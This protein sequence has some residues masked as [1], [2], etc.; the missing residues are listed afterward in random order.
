MKRIATGCLQGL[1]L[2]LGL[3]LAAAPANDHF[4]DRLPLRGL[5][6]STAG[7]NT[8]ATR[9]LGEPDHWP[10]TG[11][12]S[13]WW[14]W[15]APSDGPV[16]ITTSNSSFDTLLAVY[17]GPSVSNL[18]LV[19]NNDDAPGIWPRS[20]VQFAA[21]AGTAYQVA[22]DGFGRPDSASGSIQLNIAGTPPA[23][24]V[25]PPVASLTR[26]AD[27]AVLRI[28]DIE[29]AAEAHDDDGRIVQ[30]EFY[31][32]DTRLGQDT[33]HPYAFTWSNVPVGQYALHV[34]ATDDTGMATTSAV[35]Q[36]SVVVNPPPL[37]RLT[38][39]TNTQSFVVP[40][41]L[42][43]QADA[44]DDDG[45]Q[46][47]A[48]FVGD[49]VLGYD[50]N[51]PYSLVRSNVLAGVYALKAVAVDTLDA[52][53][54]SAVVHITVTGNYPP[55]VTLTNPPHGAA[56]AAPATIS[57]GAAVADLDGTVEKVEYYQGN[58]RLMEAT[59]PPFTAV[60]ANVSTGQY[61]L[62]A[63]A[64][65][66]GGVL[67]TS[68]P[69]SITVTQQVFTVTNLLIADNAV[70]RY[71]DNG[72]DQGTLWVGTNFDDSAWASGPAQLGYG[73]GDEATVVGYG[74]NAN[75]KYTTTYF[76][77]SF[78]LTNAAT[79]TN[80]AMEMIR[81]D[82]AVVYLNGAE[83]FRSDN[84]PLGQN[85]LT[86]TT[87]TPSEPIQP[88]LADWD[89]AFL[90]EGTNVVAVEI[91]QHA[92][93]SSDISMA[94]A[95]V[96]ISDTYV[97]NGPPTLTLISPTNGA[98]LT[99]P[100]DLV[101]RADAEDDFGIV[102]VEFYDG[103]AKL[104]Q[105]A[106]YPYQFTLTNALAGVYDIHA[107]AIDIFGVAVTSAVAQ[108]TVTG[109]YAPF[110]AIAT[111]ADGTT[112][113]APAGFIV[114]ADAVDLDG[115]VTRVEFYQGA[116]W[117]GE[118]NQAPYRVAWTE[119]GVGTY[120]L[121][122]VATDNSGQTRTSA[123]VT[124]S[125][126]LNTPPQVA[127]VTPAPNEAFIDTESIVLQA[128]ATDTD[129]GVGLVEFF[130][131]ATLLGQDMAS[132]FEFTWSGMATGTYWLSA[133]ATD[134]GGLQATSAPVRVVVVDASRAFGGLGFDGADDHVTFGLAA[135]LGLAQFTVETWFKWRGTG[136]TANT[137]GGGVNALPLVA[138][139]RGES[140][141][142]NLDMNYFLGLDPVTR[143]LVADLEQGAVPPPG[144]PGLNQPV[145]GVTPVI[146][147]VWHH[148]AVTYDGTQWHLF[149]DGALETNVYVGQ[150]PRSDSIQHASLA[151]ALNSEGAPSGYFG[152]VLDEVRIWNYPRTPGQ[153]ASNWT[154][155]IEAEAGLVG[156][157]SLDE[158]NGTVA[159]DSSGSGVHGTL[160]NEPFWT[161]GYSFASPPHVD[162]TSPLAGA[163][164][165][166]PVTIHIAASA[167]DD[168]GTVARV[169]FF[170]DD[171][172]L[173]EAPSAPYVLDWAATAPA[174][175]TLTAVATD[176][177]GLATTSAPVTILVENA[178]VQLTS[179]SQHARFVI[180]DPVPLAA[181]VSD[182]NGVIARV[183]FLDG[184]TVI[185]QSTSPPF[186]ASWVGASWGPH[187]LC[188]VAVNAGGIRSTSAVFDILVVSNLA[189]AVVIAS[190]VNDAWFYAP[191]DVTVTVLAED[192]DG[193]ITNVVFYANGNLFAEDNTRPYRPVW[194]Q[195]AL[196]TYDLQAVA[197]D[198]RGLAATS[199]VVRVAILSNTPPAIALTSPPDGRGY[200]APAVV[201]L[202]AAATD[203]DGVLRVDFFSGTN[204]LG[205]ATNAPFQFV[206][207][208]VPIGDYLLHAVATD[209]YG[210]AGTSAVVSI[211]VTNNDPP[212]VTLL[213]PTNNA[214]F[215]DLDTV[216]ILATATD[217][218]GI[219]QVDFYADNSP[220]SSDDTSPYEYPWSRPPGGGHSLVAVATDAVGLRSTSA[221]VSISVIGSVPF[222][223]TLITF[224]A[225]WKYLDNGTDQGTAWSA[226]GFDDSAWAAGPAE[227]GY[228]ESDQATTVSF[229]PDQNNV[230]ITTYFR[231]AFLVD[232]PAPFEFLNLRL[233]HDDGAVVYLNGTEIYRVNLPSGTITSQTRAPNTAE[234][235]LV[236]GSASVSLLAAGTNVVAVEMHQQSPTSSDLSFDFQL[237]AV[238]NNVLPTV[239]LTSPPHQAVFDAP[240]DVPL[241]ATAFDTGGALALVEFFVDGEKVGEDPTAPYE[242]LWTN[243]AVG[244]DFA[245]S[246]QATDNLG[247]V[248]LS[249]TVLITV[250]GNRRPTARITSPADGAAYVV[251]ATVPITVA[252]EDPDGAVTNVAFYANG[253]K[254]G[255]AA[256]APFRY[257]WSNAVIGDYVLRVLATDN[258]GLSV[259][260]APVAVTLAQTPPPQTLIPW[261]ALWRYLDNGSNPGATWVATNFN[262]ATWAQGYAQLGYGE[263]DQATTVG[264]GPDSYNKYPATFFRHSF[265]IAD[266]SLYKSLS[267]DLIMDDGAVVYINGQEAFRGHMPGGTITYRT[268]AS[269]NGENTQAATNLPATLLQTG[270]NVVAVE[271]H[272]DEGDSSDISFDL[273]LIGNTTNALPLVSITSPADQAVFTEP[274]TF[275]LT[276]SATD[277]DGSVTNVQ[278]YQD[279][280]LLGEDSTAPYSLYWPNLTA[281]RYNFTA[282]ATD[283]L[284]ASSTSAVVQVFVVV[285]TAPTVESF[286]PAEGPVDSLTQLTVN[287]A[288]PVTGVDAADLLVNGAPAVAVAGSSTTYTFF[289]PQPAEGVVEVSWAEHHGIVDREDPPKPFSGRAPGDTAR[290]QLTDTLP[291]A[292]V[293][294]APV[295]GATVPELT[296]I[297]LV[298]SEPVGGVQAADL[299]LNG[300]PASAVDGSLAGP[301]EFTV[302]SPSAGLV[303]IAWAANHGIHDFAAAQNA[304][305][306]DPWTY[307]LHAP[308]IESGILIHEIMYHPAS[309]EPREE[310]IELYNTN[311]ASVSLAGWTVTGGIDFTFPDVSISARGYL[312][313][314]ADLATFQAKYPAV[315]N[316]VGGWEGQLSN[317]D[318]NLRL[319]NALG[320]VVNEV[321]YAD[322]G[323]FAVRQRGAY[324][325]GYYGWAWYAPH[326][327]YATNT[328]NNQVESNKSLELVNPALPNN[329][330]QNW[331]PSTPANGTPG[332]PN[333]ATVADIAPLVCEVAHFPP[334]PLAT[335]AVTI[336]ARIVDENPAGPASLTLYNRNAGSTSPPNFT[337]IPMFD[338]GQN[339]DGLAG[340]GVYGAVLPAAAAGT[341]VEYYVSA[342]DSGGRTRTWPAAARQLDGSFAQTANAQYRVDNETVA[343]AMPM[344]RVILTAA[345]YQELQ[346]ML[347]SQPNS[348]AEMNCT[349]I[350]VNGTGADVRHRC[351]IRNRGAG[352]RSRSPHNYR[353]NV[354]KDNRWKDLSELNL[355]A[356]F[357][358]LQLL[359]STLALKGELP[360]AAARAVQLRINGTNPARSG[361]PVNG[362][363]TGSGFGSYLFLEPI[364]GEW[365]GLHFPDD[366]N[367]NVYRA[368]RYP[369]TANLDYQGASPATYLGLGYTKVSNQSAN[370]WSDLI[371]LTYALSPNTP[372]ANYVATVRQHVNVDQW[373]RYFAFC[374]FVN[375]NESAL[376][377]GVGDDYAMYRGI[378]DPRFLLVAHDFDTTLGMGDGDRLPNPTTSIWRMVDS[379]RSTDPASRA[380]FLT[381]FMRHNEFA[382]VYLKEYKRLL[383]TVFSPEI[384]NPT[385]DQ[386]LG[387]WVPDATQIAPIKTFLLNRRTGVLAQFQTN[388]SVS[389]PLGQSGSYYVANA[390]VITSITGYGNVLETRAVH[391]NGVPAV[392][393]AWNGNWTAGNV[394]LNPGVNAL[395]VQ[396]LGDEGAELRRQTLD[397]WYDDG[398][399]AAVPASIAE[400]LS[401]TA[402]GGPYQVSANVTVQA[403][404]TLTIEPGATLYFGQGTS[405]NIE[406]ALVA[407]GTDTRHIRLTRQPGTTATWGGIAFNDTLADNRL[408]YV[409]MEYASTGD[410]IDADNSRLLLDHVTWTGTTRTIVDMNMSSVIIRNCVFPTIADN[411]AVHGT[412]MRADGYVILEGNY[413]GGTTG[414]SDIIDFTGGQRPGPI[415][416]IL[417]NLFNGGS[418]D[419]LDLDATDAHIEG[420]T[421]LNIHQD[422]ARD[423]GSYAIA[424]DTGAAVTVVRNLFYN[425]DHAL[426][427]KNG[428]S[429]VF[430]NNTVVLIRTNPPSAVPASVICFG[431]PQ[432]PGVTG[433][434]G[435]TLDGNIFWD[436]DA[437]RHFLFFTNGAMFL[438][439]N[440]SILSGTNH[441]GTGNSRLDPRFVNPTGDFQLRSDSPARGTGP[442]GLDMG[443]YVPAGPTLTGEPL[444]PTPATTATLTVAGPGIT[445]YQYRVNDGVYQPETSVTNPIVLTG[446]TNGVYTVYVVGKT[447]AGVWQDLALP[448]ASRTWSVS[449]TASGLWINELLA[450][451]ETIAIQ[452]EHPDLVELVNR[453]SQ[454]VDLKD[455]S[456]TDDLQDP[457]QFTFP[458]GTVLGPGKYLVL[459]ADNENTP[460]GLH[461]GF[462][463]AQD[464]DALHLFSPQGQ[465]LDFVVFGLQVADLSVGRRENGEWGLT[466]PTF[467]EANVAVPVGAADVLR[468]NEWLAAGPSAG[469]PDFIELYNPNTAPA[470]LGGLYLTD[471][472]ETCQNL[473]AIAPLSYINAGGY[474]LFLADNNPDAGPSHLGFALAAE[475]GLIGLLAPDLAAIDVIAYGPQTNSI[476]MGRSPNGTTNVTFFAT[477]TPGSPNPAPSA[478]TGQHIVINEVLAKNIDIDLTH[479]F[480]P[481]L[482]DPTPEWIELYNPTPDD[483]ELEEYSLSDDASQPAKY[484]LRGITIPSQGH[485]VLMA[486]GNAPASDFNTGFGIKANGDTLYLFDKPRNGGA[487]LDSVTY[488][489]QAR[490]FSIGR[491]PDGGTNWALTVASP[492]SA[493]IV[494]TTFGDPMQLRINEWLAN[495]PP[496]GDDWIELFNPGLQPV[497]LSGLYLTDD[498]RT[499]ESR[500]KFQI[501]PLS[502]I[503]TDLYG[504]E[505]FIADDNA[506]PE[507]PDHTNFKLSADGESIGLFLNADNPV[508]HLAFGPQFE[509]LSQG[510][511]PDGTTNLALFPKGGTP[512]D[513]NYL[514]LTTVLIS[515]VLSHSNTNAL[516]DA[517]EV[518]NA[519]PAPVD[520]GGWYLSD[521]ERDLKK[522]RIPSP[523][524]VAP[525]GFAVFYEYQFN[526]NPDD[527]GSFSFDSAR[528]D[529]V[530]LSTADA[531]GN[532]T[533][534]RA[535]A[536]FDA[537]A[538]DVSFGVY[539]NRATNAL[540]VAMSRRSFGMDNPETPAE[541]RTGTG[542]PN[543]Y[544][545]VGPVVLS[546]IMYHPPDDD[547]VDNVRDEFIELYNPTDNPVPLFDPA[548]PNHTWR[549]RD[550][551]RFDFPTNLTLAARDYLLVVSFDPLQ[552]TNSLAAFRAAYHL[553]AN[554]QLA[555]PYTGKLDNGGERIDLCRPDS[556]EPPG[557]PDA[558]YVPYILVERV[559][560]DDAAPWPDGMVDGGGWSLQRLEPGDFGNDPFSWFAASPTPGPQAILDT[561]A[562]GMPDAWELAYGLVPGINDALDDFDGDGMTNLDEF[563]AGTL[564]NDP[565][566]QLAVTLSLAA[567]VRLAFVAM[568]DR[569]YVVEY[570][571][572]LT[573]GDWT[574]LSAVPAQP[575]QRTEV[576]FDP[577]S[578]HTRFYR[579]QLIQTP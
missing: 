516:E 475:H 471:A 302:V 330:G 534:Y 159:A 314:A 507:N 499:P 339:G 256:A 24:P 555:G 52:L 15:T 518:Q 558:G 503:G 355:N 259:T 35:A 176:N 363:S 496:G 569:A 243:V 313:V 322:E 200:F 1:A 135:P 199:A 136:T 90:I 536:E 431:E 493:N 198:N 155:K 542:A 197:F 46:G 456:L 127:L 362:S 151:T 16:S 271:V 208:P 73:D 7:H 181:A 424:T 468:I 366:P 454:P 3:N 203:T 104:G 459:Y 369:W 233:K 43:I 573:D 559:D 205:G 120:T 520:L 153:V 548:F 304:F 427:L 112:A 102:R 466:R 87:S 467:G 530:F 401:L 280:L 228:G 396:W 64:T 497:S 167:T 77:H 47:V 505:R 404:A 129:D 515:E 261:G 561:D 551:V 419:A 380:N 519:S 106:T 381:R 335:D 236:A 184:E 22:V 367:G 472:P 470:A 62:R 49:T 341:I 436:I 326:D 194:A 188:A 163:V 296:R 69:V 486:N 315:P 263:S 70:W 21:A 166:A 100:T 537:A 94:L 12:R 14:T 463:L 170:A 179:P 246:A 389:I 276:A 423:S 164:F 527:P 387:G 546:E 275:T 554:A 54:T 343:N 552:D 543:P 89:P 382:P 428:A 568:P 272:Q 553:P 301:Y 273:Q 212:A 50:T 328:A 433:G 178:I 53:G 67:A 9:E 8:N 500:T 394:A 295:P 107:V 300:I 183:E 540:F 434:A 334:V 29:L 517:L 544:P 143:V 478:G 522:F 132:P 484:A 529:Q 482:L 51:A 264:Y 145:R 225:G 425:N 576:V 218:D 347:S 461:L 303:D 481:T 451:N 220:L 415:I 297:R 455:F 370:D 504:F 320:D 464:G 445:D 279:T 248:T 249:P 255:D 316:V 357:I 385:A 560:Y 371:A 457:R 294:V 224:G 407:E 510:R 262:D 550:G 191:V 192:S 311:A 125:V 26:P 413:F 189:P 332:Q 76:R 545:R 524:V 409:D 231:H 232:D 492:Q 379:P 390:P 209:A 402:A 13:V 408:A 88:D 2:A 405:M 473:H 257:D 175:V 118:T 364:G 327:G 414:Y 99:V 420:N 331:A 329:H 376:C 71:L 508:D 512:G 216:T 494:V 92:P 440:H 288:E 308:V 79:Y 242:F 372:D 278:F 39:P 6:V 374:N 574:P 393:T 17:T 96:G 91:H 479:I 450:R 528:G 122:A 206:W 229:G 111:P 244:G 532:L 293:A 238:F 386:V 27:A 525:G 547:G 5:M 93:D 406:G 66:N 253:L 526:A 123:V 562:D 502:F 144:S 361:E 40:L 533:G 196:G 110:V 298:F 539:T 177:A 567:P 235:S 317:N 429:A 465:R 36:V 33:A 219:A 422:A 541:F 410:P 38:A 578:V 287:F 213:Q 133:V 240:A 207:S 480:G 252:A 305:V 157:W 299:L 284:G 55:T 152:G 501:A 417:N 483:V 68:P 346:N 186:A 435:A 565:Q 131:G 286:V 214:I 86:L 351:G 375:Y 18:T 444:S 377:N 227:L 307:A 491:V 83:V 488:G 211:T 161:L 168:D 570:R 579:V 193:S 61:V 489:V 292:I 241:A 353:I 333:S 575:T 254:L 400:D 239:L 201:A 511:L 74:G 476:A 318:D 42:V 268:W 162:I 447:S 354:P 116:T 63:V 564:P 397:V 566:S 452:G 490:D 45:L 103:P 285:S 338:D 128:A 460:P 171:A 495:P 282:V 340:D 146:P 538:R 267:L 356:N 469:T 437:N 65:D 274:A 453:G 321:H 234:N 202:E 95:L 149:L 19:A 141:A 113:V 78:V 226:P 31:Q 446:L 260:S 324:D 169:E 190:P 474:A 142:N 442:N 412:G 222:T 41:H 173:G 572:S 158:T 160:V 531:Q 319:R 336:T 140:D 124:V 20:G 150:P 56:Y 392:W 266:A 349:F 291:P 138:K 373:L 210:L 398:S 25:L 306:P 557:D 30:V 250:N 117:L 251:P 221:P 182:T 383:D 378:R 75:A 57:L 571:D 60:W 283:N 350:T 498:L 237:E 154:Q 563:H 97:S 399:L 277:R 395:L 345:E 156:R 439:V 172:R 28:G 549:L 34:V 506:G 245:L 109:N 359:C 114:E 325:R 441:P 384:F 391:V 485:I 174:F 37:V 85:Y 23:N 11:D 281:D 487:L 430:D 180:P 185:A 309:E 59:N 269:A 230:Y 84:V 265:V 139:G 4:A 509:N 223:N 416:Q 458:P 418:D 82:G 58:A 523:T 421:F 44:E 289:F 187:R 258:L 105:A 348:D 411:E 358:H 352:S 513:A 98:Q 368:S 438:S 344:Y 290:Y 121:T 81:D 535:T 365:A 388:Y 432:R 72:T 521:A 337:A 448:T 449:A 215:T 134:V 477:A 147:N 310:Y 165:L 556:P 101:L 80:L 403:G 48:F 342:T 204:R 195:P 217:M 108:V 130:M 137:G 115:I 148:A 443:A 32:G 323:D 10:G 270:T 119:V 426:L 577:D 514:P 312:V 126:A 462:G 247:G 360:V